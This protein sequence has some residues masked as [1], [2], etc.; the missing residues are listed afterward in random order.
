VKKTS[1][2]PRNTSTELT[3]GN[4][5]PAKF[6]AEVI[7]ARWLPRINSMDVIERNAPPLSRPAEPQTL[8]Q[9]GL[10]AMALS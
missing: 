5:L 2:L 7:S 10:S 4:E 1:D 8:Q 3:N 6:A 9:R